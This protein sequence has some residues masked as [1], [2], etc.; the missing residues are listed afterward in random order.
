MLADPVETMSRR[1]DIEFCASIMYGFPCLL[2]MSHLHH[3]RKCVNPKN[4][5]AELHFIN[6]RR[7]KHTADTCDC[8]EFGYLKCLALLEKEED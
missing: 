3:E 2:D 5:A 1:D 4:I 6:A 8:D 7:S